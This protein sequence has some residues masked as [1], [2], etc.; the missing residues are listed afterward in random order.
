MK[1]IIYISI[2]LLN[3]GFS[4]CD[5][6]L[7][8]DPL[9]FGN[10]KAYFGTVNDLKMYDNTFY[11]LF[12]LMKSNAYGGV[13]EIDNNSDNQCNK[14][15]ANTLF[16]Q[17]DKKIPLKK[18]SEWK[19]EDIR[20]LNY[21]IN[22]ISEKIKDGS[23]QGSQEEINH[24]LGEAYFFR[25]YDYFRL[26]R[27]F[28]DVPILTQML[29]N[30]FDQLVAASK[31]VPRNEVA[32]FIL[33]DLD[34]ASSL[35]QEKA[36]ETGRLTKDAAILMKARVALYE[37]TWEKYHKGTCFVPGNPKWTGR[38]SYPDFKFVEGS[39]E[40]EYNYFFERAIGAA[41]SIA[42]KRSLSSNYITL[43]NNINDI[44]KEEEVILARYYLLGVNGHSAGN[45][46]GR[47]GAGTGYTRALIETFLMKNGLP[48]YA[49]PE[50]K[51]DKSIMNVLI[52][53]DSRLVESVKLGGSYMF[54]DWKDKWDDIK[55]ISDQFKKKNKEDYLEEDTIAYYK[56][57]IWITGNQ[58][59][60]TGYEIRK[61]ISE[62]GGQDE[63][64][65]GTTSTPIFRAA[66]AYL[67]YLEAYYERYGD[68]SGNCDTYW[69]ALRNRAGVDPDYNKTIEVTDLTKENDLAT[70]SH[71]IYID[72][73]LYNIRRERR[74][75]FIAEGMRLD[76]LKRW[77][78][79]DQMKDY[80][81][82]GMNL[83]DEMFKIYDADQIKAGTVSQKGLGVYVRPFQIS[84]TSVVY[85]GYSFP[86]QHYL[87][88]IPVS[89]FSITGGES[90]PLYQNPGWSD[91]TAG[92]ADYTYDCD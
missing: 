51:G 14:G 36:L 56:P 16:Y 76:D 12:P 75:E 64:G 3:V 85:N 86:K 44:E 54:S 91:K 70:M 59:G 74:C 41:D 53:R 30:N 38:M 1:K 90:S 62:E 65:K 49:S 82:E 71:G 84:S 66:E 23:I 25:A 7:Q 80:Q 35:M 39:I 73:R 2:L 89:E 6:F 47:T 11:K 46:L 20:D 55:G 13:Y 27:N 61:W 88:P 50:Y 79:L 5:D 18:D 26:L 24:Y 28:G 57:Q 43:F 19:F 17:G 15:S 10:E 31:R 60:S 67:I 68:L 63:A 69:R 29:D 52:N 78:S 83:W 81:F 37:A 77:R 40:S 33:S 32:R 42:S 58:G 45:F 92:T 72:K 48:I 34:I 87:E 8:R 22:K 9:D 4:S 21:F